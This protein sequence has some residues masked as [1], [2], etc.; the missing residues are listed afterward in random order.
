MAAIRPFR[1][2]RP[3]PKLASQIAALPYDVYTRQEARAEVEKNPLSFLT[4]DR[5]ETQ[6]PE[7]V[8]MY[9]QPVY[10]RAREIFEEMAA[11]GSFIQD[12][13]P[14]YYIYT[15]TMGGRPQTGLVGCASIDDYLNNRIKK[16]E[17]TREEKEKDRIR[18]VD[19]LSAQ[20]G[21]IFLAYHACQELTAIM[22]T[23]KQEVPL[24]D[25]TSEDS[26]RHQVW[27]ISDPDIT[28]RISH[29]WEGID[30][31]YIADGHH[32]AASAVKV[33]LKRRKSHPGYD[34]TE[35]CNYFLSVL[36]AADELNIYDYNRIVSDLN[37]HTPEAFLALAH[38]SFEISGPQKDICRPSCKGE[39]GLYLAG[40]WY[41]MR[42][43]PCLFTDDPV[44]GLDVSVLQN[45]ILG[46]LL[47]I[48]DPKTDG[49]I[50]FMGG[51]RGLSALA[52]AVDAA[53]AG[54]GFAM[55]PTSMDELLA[56]ADADRLMPPKSTWFEPKLRSG[57]FI[58]RFEK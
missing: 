45:T 12:D 44:D 56:V 57:F 26:I 4:I 27:K 58:H 16:H 18:H 55:Y 46:P 36:F 43:K 22:N 37:G 2:V 19:T 6:F 52:A 3:A 54:A 34:G 38:N 9:S 7:D 24:Y 39:I 40:A 41:K 33:G 49:R 11:R 13:S 30:N 47:G 5:P 23:A 42:A 10:D 8:D 17:N 35:E 28:A 48:E 29:I 31:I 51:I 15:L 53:G 20:T 32:R 50:E 14:C 21:P 25:F 1:G